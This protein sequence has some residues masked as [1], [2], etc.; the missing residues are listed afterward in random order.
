MSEIIEDRELVSEGAGDGHQR[1]GCNDSHG[2]SSAD[3]AN[4]QLDG[5]SQADGSGAPSGLP[6]E[7][8]G[9]AT[10]NIRVNLIDDF[11]V[12]NY[13]PFPC[14][15]YNSLTGNTLHLCA[16]YTFGSMSIFPI[17][18][19]YPFILV[20]VILALKRF[21]IRTWCFC[22]HFSYLHT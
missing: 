15:K 12:F 8:G 20:R 2:G 19:V 16:L 22:I 13:N 5:Q 1:S 4:G 11:S 3:S 6:P 17:C 9:I 14:D 7:I 18:R 21:C 10:G